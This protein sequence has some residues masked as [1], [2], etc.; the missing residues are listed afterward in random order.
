MTTFGATRT[1]G[2][3]RTA[4]PH[5]CRALAAVT[6]MTLPL[7]AGT[8]AAA[9][10]NPASTPSYQVIATIPVGDCPVGLDANPLTGR[11]YVADVCDNIV[12]VI[13]GR[14]NAVAA[15]VP[16][17][18]FPYGIAVNPAT[19]RIYVPTGDDTVAVIAPRG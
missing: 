8:A 9:S 4:L 15:T 18:D 11:I 6:T 10:S 12:S 13:N 1:T 16:V 3:L 19:G 5:W 2:S 14:T 7:A 17:G